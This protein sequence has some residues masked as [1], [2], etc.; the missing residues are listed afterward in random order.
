[1]PNFFYFFFGVSVSVCAKHLKNKTFFQIRYFWLQLQWLS[2]QFSSHFPIQNFRRKCPIFWIHLFTP[3]NGILL[4]W[5]AMACCFPCLITYGHER[6]K[7]DRG[8]NM[9]GAVPSNQVYVRAL[10]WRRLESAGWQTVTG[11]KAMSTTHL[12]LD[13]VVLCSA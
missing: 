13:E 11:S 8:P 1:M 12:S 3:G 4:H 2:A 10:L 9:T 7:Q 6:R 5:E